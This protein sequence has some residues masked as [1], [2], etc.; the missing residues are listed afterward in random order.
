MDETESRT[1]RW[2]EDPF[3][4]SS[5][6]LLF[7]LLGY[8]TTSWTAEGGLHQSPAQWGA[9]DFALNHCNRGDFLKKRLHLPSSTRALTTPSAAVPLTLFF[10]LFVNVMTDT[11]EM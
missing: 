10:I 4:P 2:I 5:S 7:F 8:I 1:F 3:F 6:S 9:P 11:N